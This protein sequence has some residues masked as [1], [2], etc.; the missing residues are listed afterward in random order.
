MRLSKGGSPLPPGAPLPVTIPAA[1]NKADFTIEGDVLGLYQL[2]F[3]CPGCVQ[4][5]GAGYVK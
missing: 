3:T 2:R 1:D 5:A 4:G